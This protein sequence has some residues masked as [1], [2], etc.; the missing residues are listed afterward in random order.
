MSV[1]LAC[2][3]LHENSIGLMDKTT[4]ITKL[5]PYI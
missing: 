3:Y 4:K 1:L 5:L 2:K